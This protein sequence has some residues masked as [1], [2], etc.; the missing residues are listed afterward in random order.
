MAEPHLPVFARCIT[1]AALL[2][3]NCAASSKYFDAV[4]VLVFLAGKQKAACFAEAKRNCETCLKD[5]RRTAAALRAHRA[6][7]GC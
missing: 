6:A 5:C 2:E 4:S 7:H 1:Y 3:R